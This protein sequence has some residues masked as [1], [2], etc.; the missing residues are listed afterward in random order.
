ML[1]PKYD[2]VSGTSQGLPETIVY[3]MVR[4]DADENFLDYGYSKQN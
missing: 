1:H 4:G 2:S 3:I